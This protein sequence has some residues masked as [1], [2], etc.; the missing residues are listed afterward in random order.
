M[1]DGEL[2]ILFGFSMLISSIFGLIRIDR[3]ENEQRARWWKKLRDD[4]N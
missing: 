1:F 4:N 2:I 3:Y